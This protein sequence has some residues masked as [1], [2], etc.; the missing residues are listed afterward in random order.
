VVNTTESLSASLEDY[1]E[2]IFH[3]EDKKHA[4]RAKDIA[5]RLQVSSA[6]VTGAL[7]L[8]AEK[9]LIN[10]APYD[11]I[12]LTAK[13]K[14]VAQDV[15]HRHEM[16]RD[17]FVKILGVDEAEAEVAA[18]KMEHGVSEIILKRMTQFIEFLE[19][20]PRGGYKWIKEFESFCDHGMELSR[21]EQCLRQCIEELQ[22]QVDLKL[23]T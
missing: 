6:S 22:K 18:C 21:C 20:C 23:D 5:D 1:M 4:A 2:A 17:F 10:Y 8:L 19:T 15:V 14:E 11:I 16:L 9:E 13:G 12:T 3:I 7:R